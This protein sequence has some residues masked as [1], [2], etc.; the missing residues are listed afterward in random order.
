MIPTDNPC[1]DV[2]AD[3][4]K[5]G[6][7]VTNDG[8]SRF[9]VV[10]FGIV[11]STDNLCAGW[12]LWFVLRGVFNTTCGVVR[13]RDDRFDCAD[14]DDG[15]V[16]LASRSCNFPWFAFCISWCRCDVRCN[17]LCTGFPAAAAVALCICNFRDSLVGN[18]GC[19]GRMVCDSAIGI[20]VAPMMHAMMV[21]GFIVFVIVC[22][23]VLGF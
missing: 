6:R 23:N 19:N 1:V 11:A 12:L 10:A 8:R 20:N 3:A 16:R 22:V 13:T 4:G 17:L 21:N 9:G 5:F 15:A 18:N 2:S 14:D 7:G